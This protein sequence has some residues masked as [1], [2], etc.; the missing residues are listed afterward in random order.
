M[1][2]VWRPRRA[3]GAG[4]STPVLF[5]SMQGPNAQQATESQPASAQGPAPSRL[6]VLRSDVHRQARRPDLLLRRLL[7]TDGIPRPTTQFTAAKGNA[8]WCSK[9]CANRHW[10]R[11]RSRRRTELS[12]IAYTDLEIFE[13][14]KWRCHLC[15]KKV[16]K[17]ADRKSPNGATI[18]HLLPIALGGRDEPANVAC[19][20]NR[21]NPRE[22]DAS[23]ERTA[24]D[25][26]TLSA[27][28]RP[29]PGGCRA[30]SYPGGKQ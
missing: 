19:A 21:C 17:S 15:G 7:R 24:R 11:V 28:S 8:R 25:H 12:P 18:D 6:P 20:H 16:S 22:A 4:P 10:G 5:G 13:R 9:Q 26:L 30:E 14:D 1:R 23:D 2:R 29:L 3:I 27:A